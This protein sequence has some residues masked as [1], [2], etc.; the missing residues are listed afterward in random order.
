MDEQVRNAVLY[1]LL[2]VAIAFSFMAFVIYR[3]KRETLFREKEIQLKLRIAEGELKAIRAQINP[4]FIFNC[5]NS[6]HHFIQTKDSHIAGSF[7]IQ[8]SQLV[9]YVLESSAKRMVNLEEEI[10]H[11]KIYLKLEQ[12]RFNSSFEFEFQLEEK[13]LQKEIQIPPMFI[14]PFLENAVWH[15]LSEGGILTTHFSI[16]DQDHLCCRIRDNGKEEIEKNSYD[17]GNFVKKSSMGIQ[18]MKDRFEVY[19]ELNKTK[20]SFSFE[21]NP[22]KG[23][24]REVKII[25]PFED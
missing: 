11:N 17:L 4:H 9:R 18:L 7:L 5:L 16:F 10:E 24:G 20:A 12:M 1:S 8:F 23:K 15:G 2:P 25:I 14:Q 13:L 22:E 19:N 3:L 6:I 21:L